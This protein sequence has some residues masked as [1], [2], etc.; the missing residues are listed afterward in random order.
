MK[1][2]LKSVPSIWNVRI[3]IVHFS[4]PVKSK[5]EVNDL[6]SVPSQYPEI[7]DYKI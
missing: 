2:D 7:S 5:F 3:Y 4:S 6:H 1:F